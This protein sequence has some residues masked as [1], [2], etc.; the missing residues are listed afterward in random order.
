MNTQGYD[1]KTIYVGMFLCNIQVLTFLT[2][3]SE[4][5]HDKRQF[6]P[7]TMQECLDQITLPPQEELE[8][9]LLLEE[10]LIIVSFCSKKIIYNH[11]L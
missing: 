1:E 8:E 6:L 4:P 9:S 11:I 5:N 10:D 7:A 3:L 2:D